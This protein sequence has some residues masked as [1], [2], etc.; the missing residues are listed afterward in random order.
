MF[1]S[2][3]S[4]MSFM[5]FTS[6]ISV[7]SLMRF[8]SPCALV[9]SWR[10]TRS[11]RAASF[12]SS[13]EM[14]TRRLCDW[15]SRRILGRLCEMYSVY[16]FR[17]SP[18]HWNR[19]PN[20]SPMQRQILILYYVIQLYIQMLIFVPFLSFM[21]FMSFTSFISVMSLMRFMSP[22][23]LVT[24][25]RRTRSWRAASFESSCEMFTR[26]LCEWL[27]RRILGRL[28]EIYSVYVCDCFALVTK[29]TCTRDLR[30]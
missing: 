15:L 22:C 3:L 23:A 30:A 13:C 16:I 29:C 11:W 28:F 25:W 18:K 27:S 24:S 4:F 7:M 12:E 19:I 9:T 21:S 26:R 17:T 6:F 14:F 5:S 20:I 1:M 8:M 10:R 2:L